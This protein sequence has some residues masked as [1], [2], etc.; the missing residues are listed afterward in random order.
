[1][2]FQEQAQYYSY[3][4]CC[5]VMVWH[6]ISIPRV[7]S[8][9]LS[10]RATAVQLSETQRNSRALTASAAFSASIGKPDAANRVGIKRKRRGAV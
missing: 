4:K 7:W 5:Q 3:A 10:E 6:R 9:N 8:S 1:M 2:A